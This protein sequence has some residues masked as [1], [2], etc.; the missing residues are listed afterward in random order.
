MNLT[1]EG[2][3]IR[4]IRE[5]RGYKQEYVADQLGMSAKSYGKIES[6]ET[7][8]SISR[9]QQI[10]KVLDVDPLDVLSFDEKQVFHHCNQSVNGNHNTSNNHNLSTHERDHYEREIAHLREYIAFL[11]GQ[12][13]KQKQ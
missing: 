7:S 9:L 10:A 1:A 4:K 13:E 12:L 11:Q 3:K 5:I 6:G 8:L 2:Q